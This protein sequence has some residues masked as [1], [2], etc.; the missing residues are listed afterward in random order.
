MH[1]IEKYQYHLQITIRLVYNPGARMNPHLF[2]IP[3]TSSPGHKRVAASPLQFH[4]PAYKIDHIHKTSQEYQRYYTVYSHNQT[5]LQQFMLHRVAQK[6]SPQT[7][8]RRAR[9]L[10]RN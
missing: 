2:I 6:K 1:T 4:K 7:C 8:V 10:Y 9:A 5:V 3:E